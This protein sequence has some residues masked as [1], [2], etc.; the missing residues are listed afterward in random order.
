MAQT[1]KPKKNAT[2][3][4]T[5]ISRAAKASREMSIE[6][7]AEILVKAG[8]V[9]EEQVSQAKPKPQPAE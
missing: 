3:A 2:E 9:S 4:T 7:R 5:M 8:L 1:T 6:E